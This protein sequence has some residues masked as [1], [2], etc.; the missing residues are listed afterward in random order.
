VDVDREHVFGALPAAA[1]FGDHAVD[2]LSGL[3]EL[4]VG[5]KTPEEEKAV[6]MQ[7]RSFFARDARTDAGR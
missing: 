5:Q 1:L 4:V 6:S 2:V 3:A 7:T